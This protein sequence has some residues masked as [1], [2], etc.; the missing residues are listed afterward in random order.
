M[1]GTSLDALDLA[2]ARIEG[3]RLEMTIHVEDFQSFEFPDDLRRDLRRCARQEPMTAGEFANLARAFGAFHAESLAQCRAETDEAIDLVCAHG[4]TVFHDPPNS[5]QLLN[6]HPIARRLNC[7]VVF[8][9]RAADVAAGGQGAPMT[10]IVDA[11][12][13]ADPARETAI[14]NLGGFANFTRLPRIDRADLANQLD[15]VEAGDM[16]VCNQLL[17]H[18]AREALNISFDRD[19][20]FAMD[21]APHDGAHSDLLG[22]LSGQSTGGRSL[23]TDDECLAWVDQWKDQMRPGDLLRTIAGA[24]AQVIADRV[25]GVDCAF[26]AGGG[27]K[28]RALVFEI[29][30]RIPTAP[31]EDASGIDAH[32]RE[33]AAMAALG[34]LCQDRVPITLPRVT[35]LNAPRAPVAGTWVYPPYD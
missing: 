25:A 12:A 23:G 20:A 30:Q 34:A 24:M 16:C 19:G 29:N 13:F 22:W 9:L 14:V 11:M 7:P 3:K 28:N 35:G 2:L 26:L 1:T 32:N 8:D 17:D 10:P 6:P 31:L 15:R 27:S 18:A 21:G 5:L 4:Q 33:A